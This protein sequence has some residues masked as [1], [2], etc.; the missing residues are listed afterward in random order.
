MDP[1]K[2]SRKMKLGQSVRLATG[3][4]KVVGG[5]TGDDGAPVIFVQ[6]KQLDPLTGAGLVWA[7]SPEDIHAKTN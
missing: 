3:T 7:V 1:L 5:R 4:A 2:K 6:V